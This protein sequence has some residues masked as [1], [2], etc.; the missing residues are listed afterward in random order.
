MRLSVVIDRRLRKASLNAGA[1][2]LRSG[3][4]SVAM[5]TRSTCLPVPPGASLRSPA[6]SQFSGLNMDAAEREARFRRKVTLHIL[7]RPDLL[8]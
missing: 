7:D 3:S 1:S 6:N 5:A 4:L 2:L 8:R